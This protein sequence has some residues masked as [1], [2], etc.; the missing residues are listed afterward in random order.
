MFHST[1][2]A[3][4]ANQ[5]VQD[6]TEQ[7]RDD[8]S[9]AGIPVPSAR[10]LTWL[11]EEADGWRDEELELTLHPNKGL[12]LR[13]KNQPK[14]PGEN[15]V[16]KVKTASQQPNRARVSKAIL[17]GTY[18]GKNFQRSIDVTQDEGWDAVFWTESAVEKFVYPY[19]HAHRIWDKD[20]DR[21]RE[22]FATRPEA[23][24]IRH[25]APSK[26]SAMT[27][28]ALEVAVLV[29]KDIAWLSVQKFIEFLESKKS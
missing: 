21:V 4:M 12:R 22:G 16:L 14:D 11:A 26:S 2:E 20:M 23:V 15:A 28:S 25:K 19:Y 10:D 8:A 29:D 6:P 1:L 18:Q 9:A 27:A 13:R 24:A 3:P 7:G 17:Q 5:A